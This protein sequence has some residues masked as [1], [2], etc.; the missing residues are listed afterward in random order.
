MA[1]T[2][3]VARN[4]VNGK[5]YVGQSW[6]YQNRKRRHLDPTPTHCV[7]FKAAVKKYGKEAFSFSVIA[8]GIE[9]QELL[10]LTED[11][12]IWSL[13]SMAPSGYNLRWGGARGKLTEEHKKRISAANKGQ[14]ITEEQKRHLSAINTGKKHSEAT[15]EKCRIIS[16][17]RR[18]TMESRQKMSMVQKG[19]PISDEAKRKMSLAKLGRKLSEETRKKMSLAQ[20]AR[21]ERKVGTNDPA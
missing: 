17:G 2:V 3:Y 19:H 14:V 10:D 13:M 12:F 16:T 18:H 4:S 9:D 8:D 21:A 7:A 11:Y 20:R 5:M 6:E 15:K 1:G